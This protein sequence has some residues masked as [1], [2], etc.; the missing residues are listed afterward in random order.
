MVSI[1]KYHQIIVVIFLTIIISLAF[2]LVTAQDGG[3]DTDSDGMPDDW[4]E[5]HG[6]DANNSSDADSDNDHDNMTNKEEYE[7]NTDPNDPDSDNDGMHDD[8]EVQYSLDPN[9]PADAED[10]PD[11]DGLKNRREYDYNT[12]PNDPR[13]PKQPKSGDGD[14]EEA[15]SISTS[16]LFFLF[17]IVPTVVVLIVIILLYTKVR[18]ERLLE[19]KVRGD[20]F[21]LINKSPGVHYRGIMS[22]LGIQMG[23][24]THHLNMLE[25]QRYIKSYQDGMYRRFY[26]I[27]HQVGTSLILSEIQERVLHTLQQH[28]GISQVELARLLN[29]NRKI[30]HYHV[31]ILADAGFVHIEP[32]GRESR[33]YYL[34]GLDIAPGA[35]AGKPSSPA[36]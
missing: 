26:P 3:Q 36:G 12:N 33:C 13:D 17:F 31:K 35:S 7:N 23:Q 19:H 34:G 32:A 6:L 14:S 28:P 8:W 20:I 4:E 29:Q 25:T 1:K 27:N 5:K 22:E 15:L 21:A 11:G 9:D 16:P 2:N 18:R 30:V 10:D 24:L